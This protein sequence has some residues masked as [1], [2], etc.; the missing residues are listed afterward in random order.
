[1]SL[2]PE[3]M[4]GVADEDHLHTL[5]RFYTLYECLLVYFLCFIHEMPGLAAQRIQFIRF[6]LPQTLGR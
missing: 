5:R 3:G 1:M 6:A 2:S 4:Y